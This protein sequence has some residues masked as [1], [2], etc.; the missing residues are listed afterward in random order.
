[1]LS[2]IDNQKRR[3]LLIEE[4]NLRLFNDKSF[5]KEDSEKAFQRSKDLELLFQMR[6]QDLNKII[7]DREQEVQSMQFKINE[8]QT[9]LQAMTSQE[10]LQVVQDTLSQGIQVQ[11]VQGV[12]GVQVQ[13]IV[14][15]VVQEIPHQEVQEPITPFWRPF[16]NNVVDECIKNMRCEGDCNHMTRKESPRKNI[17]CNTCKEILINYNKM[18]DHRKENHPSK[19]LCRNGND[20]IYKD[21]SPGCWFRHTQAPHT[22]EVISTCSNPPAIFTCKECNKI[23]SNINKMMTHKKTDHLNETYR[24]FLS[25]KCRR[26]ERRERCWFSHNLNNVANNIVPNIG[27]M[28]DFPNLPTTSQQTL[29]V[30]PQNPPQILVGQS[31]NQT[32]NQIMANM[33]AMMTHFMNLNMTQ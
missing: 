17:T 21:R 27:S 6:V 1:M 8:Y 7:Q 16:E 32:K 2:F 14:S 31:Q 12:Q 25:N 15:Q 26:G 9:S 3:M 19:K 5:F 22:S 20:C 28:S 13:E 11:G 33:M 18:M 4:E 30:G 23:F 10:A 29:L 24:D